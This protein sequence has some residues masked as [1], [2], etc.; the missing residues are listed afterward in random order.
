MANQELALWRPSTTLSIEQ[1]AQRSI[2]TLKWSTSPQEALKATKQL[3]GAW[4]HANP[5]DPAGYAASL[6]AALAAYPLGLV[7]ECCDP[8][9]GLAKTREF[10]PTVQSIN[11][12]CDRR[13]AYHR[14]AIKHGEIK[15]AE[16]ADEAKF[17]DDHRKSMLGRLQDLMHG[18]FRQS[19][20][21]AA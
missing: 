16:A 21:E 4:P 9:T 13:L 15:A 1:E 14:G 3:I 2:V 18:L 7:Q 11:E 8:R 19:Q 10:P 5:P 6:A 17:T 12:W 20:Q